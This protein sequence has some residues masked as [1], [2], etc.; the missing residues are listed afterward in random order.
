[1]SNNIG[2]ASA[3]LASGTIVS[4]VLGFVKAIVLVQTIGV[5]GRSADAF[6]VANQLPNSI[7][8]I[9]AGGV[10]SAILVPQIVRAALHTD[11]GRGYINKLITVTLV[12][13]TGTTVLATVLA[14]IIT[15]MFALELTPDQYALATAFAY[16]CLPQIFFYGLYT[17]LGEVLNAHK[18]FGP[19]TW[20]PVLNN[21]VAILGLFL[22]MGIFGA[23]PDGTQ[24]VSSWTPSMIALLAGSA[25]L[26][27]AGQA[28]ILFYFWRRIG[29]SYRPDF[30]WRGVGLGAAGRMA[31]WTFGML[32][33]TQI[34]GIVETNVVGSA[35]GSNASVTVLAMAWLIFMLPHSIITVSIATAYFTRLS[36]HAASGNMR[37][38]IADV[39]G[40][41]RGITTI[42]MIATAV[43]IVVAYP[44]AA[45]FSWES[46]VHTQAFGNV[47]IAYLVGLVAF[48]IL[49]VL[50]RTF[51]A[52]SD[53]K[54][55]FYFTLFQVSLVVIGTLGCLLLPKDLTAVGIGSVITIAG[56]AQTVVAALLLRRRIG[57]L[58]SRRIIRSL[59]K[60]AVALL[61]PLAVGVLLIITLGGTREGG[62]AVSGIVQA[63]ISMAII[64]FVMI[65]LYIGGLC[66]MRSDELAAAVG[67]MMRRLRRK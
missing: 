32:I 67:P 51:Y 39:S 8:V 64:G 45:I 57:H 44:F 31:G 13:L 20:A 38:L 42:I 24:L 18:S 28:L 40:A 66:L 61:I 50:Q 53:T 4:R 11:G 25:T 54:T 27:V 56:T 49:F 46:F 6:S 41:T 14:P 10:L 16:W 37:G 29:L 33:L 30:R 35:S 47:I 36:E 63:M 26:G 58:D 65:V 22:F 2:K 60:N 34:A 48:S 7:Y 17:V 62:F 12:I 5:L 59:V 3:L 43:L 23:D 1:M 9:V 15:R 19:F 21:V 55:P 52:L